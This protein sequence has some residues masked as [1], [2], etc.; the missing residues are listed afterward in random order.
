[1]DTKSCTSAITACSSDQ[2]VFARA[3]NENRILISADTDFGTTLALRE[4]T[5]PSL[6]LFRRGPRIPSLQAQLLIAILPRIEEELARGCIVVLGSQRLRVRRLPIG[7]G[8]L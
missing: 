7:A 3:A 6:I 4:E 8:S 2:E 5:K 1:L